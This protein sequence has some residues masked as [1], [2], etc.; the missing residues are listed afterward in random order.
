[1][2]KRLLAIGDIHGCFEQF[3]QMIV[4]KIRATRDDNIILVG[5]YIDRGPDSRKVIDFI[6]DLQTGGFNIVPLRGNHE[7]MLLEAIEKGD[8]SLWLRNGGAATLRSFGIEAPRELEDRY[9]KFFKGLPWYFEFEKYL[10]VH[11][12]LND[13]DTD[14][15]KDKVSMVWTRRESYRNPGL[16][17][18]IIVH[19]H[20]P[21]TTDDCKRNVAG[22]S[23]VINID[24]GCVYSEQGLGTL[25]A[26]E[27]NTRNLYFVS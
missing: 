16:A 26:I 18:R 14:P 9:I 11:A 13:D 8:S 15:F 4:D 7:V 27:L 1:M 2:T 6:L 19:G 5:D 20:T 3:R 25:T 22:N 17:G 23:Q 24:T 12:G 21:V 10:F